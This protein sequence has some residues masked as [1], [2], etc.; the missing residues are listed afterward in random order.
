[1]IIDIYR[2]SYYL[3]FMHF[4]TPPLGVGG[5]NKAKLFYKENL[6]DG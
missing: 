3:G 6:I 1:M 5:P 2:I 4:L